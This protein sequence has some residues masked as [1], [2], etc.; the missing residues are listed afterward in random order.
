MKMSMDQQANSTDE[1]KKF[2]SQVR[3]QNVAQK[4]EKLSTDFQ[5]YSNKV[6]ELAVLDS[7]TSYFTFIAISDA[8]SARQISWCTSPNVEDWDK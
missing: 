7:C 6:S 4:W 8:A 5:E 3:K 2:Y 1:L